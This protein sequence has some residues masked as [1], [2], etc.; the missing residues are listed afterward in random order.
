L[1]SDAPRPKAVVVGS[2]TFNFGRMEQDTKGSHVFEI[3]NEGDAP[4]TLA[5]GSTTCK[6]TLSNLNDDRLEPGESAKVELEWNAVADERFRHSATIRTNDP[7]HPYLTLTIQGRVGRSHKIVPSDLRFSSPISVGEGATARLHLYSFEGDQFHVT[8]HQFANTETADNFD[9]KIE[10]MPA[11]QVA[12]EKEAKA[13]KILN[14]VVKPGLPLGPLQQRIRLSLDLPGDPS[15]DVPI[16]GNV[17]GDI[18]IVGPVKGSVKWLDEYSL[19]NLGTV[20]SDKG[21]KSQGMHLLVKG[22]HRDEVNLKIRSVEPDFLKVE[23]EEPQPVPGQ[24]VVKIPFT[25]EVPPKA[26]AGEHTNTI[27]RPFGRIEIDTGHPTTP[28]LQIYLNFTVEK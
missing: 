14:L 26:P 13:G 5:K 11:D 18:S 21:A 16:E 24:A 6:C 7:R 25:I 22:Q 10:E 4:L 9:L 8:R 2:D 27:D 3:R 12:Q 17:I 23:F 20:Q 15:V 19:L 1:N 28:R